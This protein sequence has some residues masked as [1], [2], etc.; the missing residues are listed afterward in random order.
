MLGQVSRSAAVTTT[1]RVDL[2]SYIWVQQQGSLSTLLPPGH[3]GHSIVLWSDISPPGSKW[4]RLCSRGVPSG[5]SPL[6]HQ[7]LHSQGGKGTGHRWAGSKDVW[8]EA[9][10]RLAG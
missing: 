9:H 10:L 2:S 4:L 8:E 7:C 6:G 1:T 5:H 3:S